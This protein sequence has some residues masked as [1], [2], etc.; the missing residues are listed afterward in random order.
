MVPL[1]PIVWGFGLGFFVCLGVFCSYCRKL[2]NSLRKL[3]EIFWLEINIWLS[4]QYSMGLTGS[5]VTT[6]VAWPGLTLDYVFY[7]RLPSVAFSS[8]LFAAFCFLHQ[9]GIFFSWEPEELFCKSWQ[10][11]LWLCPA[12]ASMLSMSH[13]FLLRT[14]AWSLSF[15]KHRF[16][17]SAGS[18]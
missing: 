16:P 1:G 12:H 9:N 10:L 14:P 4:S 11:V 17:L 15:N 3:C 7:P 8:L 2:I 6:S 13:I 18:V 5:S